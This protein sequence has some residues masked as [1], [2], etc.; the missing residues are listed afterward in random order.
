M[1]RLFASLFVLGAVAGG[2]SQLFTPTGWWLNSAIGVRTTMIVLFALAVVVAFGLPWFFARVGDARG[3][4]PSGVASMLVLWCGV[5]VALAVTLFAR[6][7]GNIFPIVMVFA[8]ALSAMA[9]GLGGIAGIG[10]RLL[11]RMATRV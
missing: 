1:T 11:T 10:L 6:G 8:A 2:V 4:R 5:M 9:I 3:E 7:A